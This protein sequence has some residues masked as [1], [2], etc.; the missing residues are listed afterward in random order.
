[1]RI[2]KIDINPR[3][4]VELMGIFMIATACVAMAAA[5]LLYIYTLTMRPM[6]CDKD[7]VYVWVSGEYPE[8][9]KCVDK[10][11]HEAHSET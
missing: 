10:N 5:G 3:Y 2:G 7:Q 4:A 8:D 6:P 1:M 9:A 11:N